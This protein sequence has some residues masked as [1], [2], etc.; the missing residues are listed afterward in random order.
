MADTE[1]DEEPTVRPFVTFLN[2]QRNGRMAAELADALHEATEAVVLTGKAATLTLTVRIKPAGK[3]TT[4]SLLV[5]DD[6]ATKL[7]KPERAETVFFTDRDHNLRRDNPDAPQFPLREVGAL[8]KPQPK[9]A[10]Q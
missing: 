2:E 3:G 5:A 1:H 9:E 10:S 4:S 7:P 8:P 6:I